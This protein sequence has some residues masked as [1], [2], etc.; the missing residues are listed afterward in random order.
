MYEDA[1]G[2]R[3]NMEKSSITFGSKVYQH[4]RDVLMQLL[5]I[6]NVGGGGKYLGLPEQFGQKKQKMLQYIKNRVQSKITGWQTR[7]LSTAG[8]E[9]LIKAVAFAMPV[10]S[11]NVFQ[12]PIELCSEIN[13]MIARFWWGTTPENKKISWVSWKKMNTSK[14]SGGLGFRDLHQFNQALLANQAW[15]IIQQ[16]ESLVHKVLKARYFRDGHL[17]SANTGSKPSYGWN[18]QRFGATILRRGVRVSIG[19]GN[20]T[21]LGEDPWL[22]T[23]PPQAP[24][25]LPSTDQTLKVADIID[26][27]IR[28]WDMN[29]ISNLIHHD[30]HHLITKIYLPDQSVN[31]SLV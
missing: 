30:E 15:K 1:S 9:I 29:K 5:Q 19:N 23:N 8:N 28:H 20:S 7:F 10:Y 17:L 22:P 24:V 25:L 2:Q 14:K 16:P 21:K 3:I 18:S 27:N 26:A 6:P 13:S 12:L 11:M 31:D 4:T